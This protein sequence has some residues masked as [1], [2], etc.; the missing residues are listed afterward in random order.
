MNPS[1]IEEGSRLLDVATYPEVEAFVTKHL[2]ESEGRAKLLEFFLNGNRSRA[3]ALWREIMKDAPD[4]DATAQNILRAGRVTS[5]T[6]DEL[7]RAEI[8]FGA[9]TA[10]LFNVS[11]PVEQIATSGNLLFAIAVIIAKQFEKSAENLGV[12]LP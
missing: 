10:N 2:R 8:A 4:L 12:R 7:R 6:Q 5:L 11:T 9:M 1:V 3:I